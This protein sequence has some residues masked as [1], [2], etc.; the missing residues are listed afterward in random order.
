MK[1][2]SKL[3]FGIG[4]VGLG[5]G[6]FGCND[7]PIGTTF[8]DDNYVAK[9]AIVVPTNVQVGFFDIADPDNAGISFDLTSRGEDVSNVTI[10]ASF[11]GGPEVVFGTGTV[12]STVNVDM[13]ELLT[14][15][16]V[17]LADVEIGDQATFTF[18][19][20]SASGVSRSSRSLVV[21]FTCSSN[22]EGT[23]DFVSTNLQA[24]TGSCPTDPVNGQVTWT[25]RGGGV[26]HTSDLGFG[27]YGTTCW[28]D[29][30]ATSANATFSDVC[31][32]IISGGLDQYG[33]TYTWIITDVSG[34]NLSMS[35][36]ND[37]GDSGDVVL[38]RPDG[39]D[40]PP[41]YTE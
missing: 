4:M 27:Q 17:N 21:P 32:E 25:A 1:Q 12:G 14:L 23:Y 13:N 40:W 33:L 8:A 38:T 6:L 36:Y 5:I 15:L 7:E 24:I 19:A 39:S 18:D 37:Y 2:L 3:C 29:A 9:G 16:G 30:P 41:L 35:W 22:L 20:E 31:N 28:N 10:Y 11:E 34:P 26:Y